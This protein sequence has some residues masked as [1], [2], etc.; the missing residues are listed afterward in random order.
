MED[1]DFTIDKIINGRFWMTEYHVSI[2]MAKELAMVERSPK[3]KQAQ[4]TH[5]I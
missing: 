3:G 5:Q 4:G 1:E 2:D